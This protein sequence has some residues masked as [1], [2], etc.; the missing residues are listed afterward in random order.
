M[1]RRQGVLSL[2][3]VAALGVGALTMIAATQAGAQSFPGVDCGSKTTRW[4]FWPEGHGAIK[5]QG[6]PAFPTPHLEVY[7][8][9]GKK[10]ADADNIA[11]ADPTTSKT[12][13]TCT[14]TTITQATGK[15]NKKLTK[16]KELACTFPSNAV[17]L[18]AS[19]SGGGH[20]IIAYVDGKPVVAAT[21]NT[22][23]SQL[24][25]DGKLC[26]PTKPPK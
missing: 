20:V 21:L 13:S 10:F 5:S 22:T 11:Y 16:T 6:F 7:K 1:G 23:G 17:F 24:Q 19:G 8:G 25:Y 3:L 12:A 26:K 4:L 9:T 18:A 15:T 14:A 2:V